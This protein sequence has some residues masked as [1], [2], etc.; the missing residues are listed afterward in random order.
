MSWNVA[1]LIVSCRVGKSPKGRMLYDRQVKVLQLCYFASA[2]C[3]RACS[4]FLMHQA[5]TAPHF[6]LP[7]SFVEGAFLVPLSSLAESV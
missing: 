7:A 1:E 5:T 6:S 2:A 3:F 4:S